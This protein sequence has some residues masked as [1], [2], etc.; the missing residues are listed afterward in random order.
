MTQSAAPPR[1]GFRLAGWLSLMLFFA[2][3]VGG[4]YHVKWAPYYARGFVAAAHHSIGDSILTGH[5]DAAAGVGWRAGWAYSITYL[6]AI[7]QALV[8]GLALGAGA[9]ALLPASGLAR[10]FGGRAASLR[11]AGLAVPSMMCTCCA[12]PVAVGLIECEAGAAAAIIYWLANPVL[13]P[14]TLVFIGFVLGWQWTLLRLA[15]GIPLVFVLGHA[16]AFAMPRGRRLELTP[17]PAG[18]G[19]NFLL[20]W[21]RA[22]W[23]LAIRLVPEYIVIVF[24][25]GALRAWLFPAMSPAIG[26]APWLVPALAAAGTLFV[27]P[28]AG[29]VPI[30][31]VLQHFGLGA[32]G[33]AALLITLPAVSLPSLAMLGR[34]LPLRA[35]ALL[36][37]GTFLFGLMAAG[38]AAMLGI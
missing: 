27:I 2:I 23:R 8:L 17:R 38:A 16:A 1:P 12:A 35:L 5:A 21:A 29:E 34:V 4:L 6:K 7:W 24:A 13:N 31:Q 32:T 19:R 18:P 11:A 36:G 20:E 14:A 37:C 28:T 15:V 33:A 22:F 10:F 3:A 26:H 25:L 30:I 9:Q